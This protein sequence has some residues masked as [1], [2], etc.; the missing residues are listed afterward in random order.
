[1]IHRKRQRGNQEAVVARFAYA[2][3]CLVWLFMLPWA[4]AFF[5][6]LSNNANVPQSTS[7]PPPSSITSSENS[8]S[9]DRGAIRIRQTVE[10]DLT[11]VS[12]ML[13]TAASSARPPSSPFDWKNKMNQL[14]TQA[15]ISVLM[16]CRLEA[17][18]EGRKAL[19]R[20]DTIPNLREQDRL[21]FLWATS[22]KLRRLIE[23]ASEDTGEDNVWRR[24]NF[25]LTPADWTWF[26]HLQLTAEHVETNTVV[27][28]CEVAMLSN[29]LLTMDGD[30]DPSSNGEEDSSSIKSVAFS[31]AI[32]NLATAPEWRRR[33]IA[34]RMLTV[35]ER[36]VQRK[37][38]YNELGLFVE[39]TNDAALALYKRQG[40][41]TTV[42]CDGGDRLGELW[43]MVRRMDE[44]TATNSKT[45]SLIESEALLR[46]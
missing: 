17:M 29:P 22:D 15:D 46:R 43:Y 45:D 30:K 6:G 44:E 8:G 38:E 3:L 28:F 42:T 14:F 24:H 7:S 21:K 11:A 40:Y 20:L 37:W 32:T 35:A 9:F 16:R 10:S 5:P 13:S 41:E 2:M 34:S 33:G 31:P 25:A 36:V 27:G 23:K 26:H 4:N 12:A 1:M 19:A 39:K 18:D